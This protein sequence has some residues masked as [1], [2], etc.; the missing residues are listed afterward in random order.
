[1]EW[2]EPAE[3]RA[4]L[5]AYGIP[6]GKTAFAA[7]P[8]EAGAAARAAGTR[9]ALKICSPQ[10]Q[11]KSEVGGVVLDLEGEAAVEAAARAMLERVRASAPNAELTGFSVEPMVDRG[12]AVEVIIGASAHG[13]FG[14]VIL[15]GEGGTAVEALADTAIEL[16]PL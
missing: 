14:P 1:R 12:G 2:L 11:H 9:V 4:V 16:P 5:A 7:S 15:F 10:I 6:V 13:D 8:R 3:A